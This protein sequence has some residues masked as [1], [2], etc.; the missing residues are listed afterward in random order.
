MDRS[1]LFSENMPWARD[2]AKKVHQTLPASFELDDLEQEALLEHSK[3]V[4]LYDPEKNGSYQGYAYLWVK[5]AVLMAC[6]RGNW[7]AATTEPIRPDYVDAAPLQDQRIDD[8]RVERS[9]AIRSE[10]QRR[11]VQGR[12]K[13]LPPGVAYL[14]RR[15]YLDGVDPKDLV[16]WLNKP[17]PAI[18]RRLALG[19]RLLKKARQT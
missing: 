9:D 2:I 17:Y 7:R 6:R 12:L 8:A 10:R 5:G 19:V 16:L 3:R 11:W 13:L 4:G 1:Q 15:V 18:A 14:V